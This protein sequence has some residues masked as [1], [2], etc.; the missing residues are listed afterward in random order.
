MTFTQSAQ[1]KRPSNVDKALALVY[2]GCTFGMLQWSSSKVKVKGLDL[3]A[4][5]IESH[6]EMAVTYRIID[7]GLL[8]D[9]IAKNYNE[10]GRVGYENVIQSFSM[11]AILSNRWK[12][13]NVHFQGLLKKT[14][15][16]F[17]NGQTLG[18]SRDRAFAKHGQQ[19]I[20]ACK[21]AKQQVS[22]RAKR[23]GI[24]DKRWILRTAKNLL[25]PLHAAASDVK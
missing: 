21:L 24:S 6:L 25:P 20:A 13:P 3:D 15:A 1:A 18:V 11:A 5:A 19:A 14:L 10:V 23:V 2:S 8:S 17:R 12:A 4:L 9:D 7:E 16:H 22:E